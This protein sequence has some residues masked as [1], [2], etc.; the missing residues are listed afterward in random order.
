MLGPHAARRPA[1]RH[2]VRGSTTVAA[3]LLLAGAVLPGDSPGSEAADP[4]TDTAAETTASS[5]AGT[6]GAR[7]SPKEDCDQSTLAPDSGPTDGEA[8]RRIKDRGRLV[9]GVDQNSYLWGYRDPTSGDFKGFD[10]ALA[11]ALATHVLGKDKVAFKPV[12]TNKRTHALRTRQVDMVVRAMSITCK[13]L[14]K[15]AF[16]APYFETGQQILTPKTSSITGFN[17]TLGARPVCAARGSTGA[18]LLRDGDYDANVT[19]VDN[20]LDCL[21][22]LQL[23]QV[24]GVISDRALLA[25]QAAQ[26]PSTKLVGEPYGHEQYGVAMNKHDDALVRAVNAALEKITSGGAASDWRHNYDQWL[27]DELDAT[28][29]PPKPTYRD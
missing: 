16:S 22:R 20:Q 25:G 19:L 15:V 29:G 3:A 2:R 11:H 21:V 5:T 28:D 24:E 6:S 14:E 12:S 8:V 9:V 27:R 23:G 26:D 18:N 4:P 13:R 7:K 1:A 17:T 10:V